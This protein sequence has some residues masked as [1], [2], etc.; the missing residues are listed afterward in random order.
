MTAICMTEERPVRSIDETSP[1]GIVVGIDFSEE[2]IAALETAAGIARRNKLALHALSVIP[3]LPS[4]H[5]NPGISTSQQNVN[6][7]RI[8]LKISELNELVSRI[9]GDPAWT[10]ECRMGR[11]VRALI[12]VAELRRAE[13]IVV[14]RHH[15]GLIDTVLKNETTLNLMRAATMPVLTMSNTL[16]SPRKVVAAVD[17]SSA[18]IAAARYALSLMGNG[19][20]FTLCYVEPPA[21]LLPEG[22]SLPYDEEFPGDIVGVFN[23]VIDALDPPEGVR[24]E[25]GTLTGHPAEALLSYAEHSGADL[26]SLGSHGHSA[27]GRFV[28][29][30]VSTSLTK[31]AKCAV[32]VAPMSWSLKD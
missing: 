8:D 20:T 17:F 14:G 6:Q 13:L 2:S 31:H 29:G 19:G 15:H 18:S 16:A 5:I 7:L 32:L 21:E 9:D 4:Y 25:K 10:L 1:G 28:L 24:I 27:I 23:S 12:E 22:F 30:S 26:I 11:A 3:S